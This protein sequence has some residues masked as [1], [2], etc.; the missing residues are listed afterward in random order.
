MPTSFGA[1]CN[2]FSINAT[3]NLKMD[4]PC[5]RESIMS[6][7]DRVRKARP[8][9]DKFRRYDDEVLLESNRREH[10]YTW[11]ALRQNS[12]RTGHANPQ[13][14]DDAYD[15]HKVILD[16]VPYFLSIS[17][18]DVDYIELLFTFDLECKGNHDEVVYEALYA[19]TPVGNLLRQPF[20]VTGG[21]TNDDPFDAEEESADGVLIDVQPIFRVNL[22]DRGDLQASFEVKTRERTR[23]GNAS[24]SR[25]EPLGVFLSMRRFGPI[26]DI[27][28]LSTWL[29]EMGKQCEVLAEDRLIPNLLTPIAR[30]ITSGSA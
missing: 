14:M 6:L 15:Y 27:S 5:E 28:D 24:R 13:S 3:I 2:D 9:M 8:N 20:P 10:E 17:P 26:T 25:D 18:L 19:D 23:R 22:S 7:F 1:L 30:Y 29:D 12:V 16:T 4:L 21:P 11:V